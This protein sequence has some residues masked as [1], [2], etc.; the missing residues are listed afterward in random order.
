MF[1]CLYAHKTQS[2]HIQTVE[3][4]QRLMTA[5]QVCRMCWQTCR[6][7]VDIPGWQINLLLTTCLSVPSNHH[8]HTVSGHAVSHI[9]WHD[10][11]FAWHAIGKPAVR[12]HWT[13]SRPASEFRIHR[14][15][16]EHMRLVSILLLPKTLFACAYTDCTVVEAV[17]AALL[18]RM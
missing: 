18:L 8:G 10:N 15:L 13:N 7:C 9:A 16:K 12:G 4:P 14:Y 5:V 3:R 1:T 2:I 6:F 17:A 11:M